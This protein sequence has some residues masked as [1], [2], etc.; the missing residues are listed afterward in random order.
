MIDNYRN[1]SGPDFDNLPS[2]TQAEVIVRFIVT[3]SIPSPPRVCLFA[4]VVSL[5]QSREGPLRAAPA[6]NPSPRASQKRY[7]AGIVT[8]DMLSSFNDAG[9]PTFA[10]GSAGDPAQ[11]SAPRPYYAVLTQARARAGPPRAALCS[12]HKGPPP[13]TQ[14][15][16]LMPLSCFAP[17]SILEFTVDHVCVRA[18][19]LLLPRRATPCP[20][21][22]RPSAATT[23]WM[24]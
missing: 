23:T 12:R 11:G 7:N 18:P 17:C 6:R 16:R 14:A 19:V 24:P 3:R 10:Y 22:S 2:A 13:A 15:E 21:P 20:R 9:K 1:L 5:R 4:R 8:F